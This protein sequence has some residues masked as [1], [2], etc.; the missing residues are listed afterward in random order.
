LISCKAN[1]IPFVS[2]DLDLDS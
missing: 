1:R 2:Q